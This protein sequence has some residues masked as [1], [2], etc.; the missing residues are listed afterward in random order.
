M[1]VTFRLE[2]ICTAVFGLVDG[3]NNND[4]TD[5][6]VFKLLAGLSLCVDIF[7]TLANENPHSKLAALYSAHTHARFARCQAGMANESRKIHS[8]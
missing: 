1:D 5:W 4:G 3:D 7:T 6:N 2:S 8:K